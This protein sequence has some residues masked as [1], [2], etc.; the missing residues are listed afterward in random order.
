MK[1]GN[2]TMRAWMLRGKVILLGGMLL[3]ALLGCGHDPNHDINMEQARVAADRVHTPP[4]PGVK[5][6]PGMGDNSGETGCGYYS[7]KMKRQLPSGLGES[8]EEVRYTV[9]WARDGVEAL[10]LA[11]EREYAVIILD[12]ML[13][14]IDGWEVC[15]TLRRPP[16]FHTDPDAHRPWRPRGP[17]SRVRNRRGR[18]PAQAVRAAGTAG[19]GAGAHPPRGDPPDAAHSD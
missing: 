18:L 9:D 2:N 5:M 15:A 7:S 1:K 17:D 16:Q 12:L 14:G 4:K 6:M 11:E 8:L 19:Q 13:P 3:G 10:A